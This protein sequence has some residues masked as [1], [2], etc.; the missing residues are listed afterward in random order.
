M[1]KTRVR[2]AAAAAAM[3]VLAAGLT[4][5][6]QGRRPLSLVELANIPRILD[7]QIAPDGRSVLYMLN[8]A[9]WKANR[10]VGHLWR[11]PI[12]GGAPTQLTFGDTGESFGRW[13][14]DGKTILFLRGGQV[15]LL[16]VDGGEPRA[17]TRHATAT[18]QPTWSPD[19]TA[20]YFVSRDA[21]TA[22]ERERTSTNDDLAPFEESLKQVHLWKAVVATG[23]EQRLTEGDWSVLGYK[24]S[25]DGKQIVLQ[26]APSTL[27]SDAFRGEVWIVDA[28]GQNARAV[29]RNGIDESE[30]QLSPDNSTILF[31][32]D[33][34][35]RL[36]PYYPRAIFTMPAN[37][38]SLP[39]LLL[40]EFPYEIYAAMWSADGRSIYAL[41]SMGVH[42]EVFRIDVS[43]RRAEKLTEGRHFIPP[44]WSVSPSAGLMLIQFDE[45]TRFGDAWTLPLAGGTPTRV[46]GIYDALERDGALPRQEKIEWKGADGTT[47]EGILFYPLDYQA[48]RRY[49]LVVQMHGGPADADHYGAGP[50]L[51]M[52]YVPVLTAKG[53]AVLRP[54]YRG[55][56]GYGAA[57]LRDPIGGYFRNM[58]LDVL[59]GVD[60]LVARGIAD[61]DKLALMG[62]SAGGHLTNKLIT[63]TDRFKAASS[64]AG[65]ANWTSMFSQTD[66][67]NDRTLIFGGTPWQKNAPTEMYWEQSPLKYVANVKTPTL[68]FVGDN[69]N[70]VPKEQSIEMHRALKANG[71]PTRL[72]VGQREGHQWGELR[73][74]IAK[75]NYELEWF[76]KHLMG[77]GYTPEKAPADNE[78]DRPRPSSQ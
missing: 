6:A 8:R 69:D 15:Q 11:Q 48:G 30:A 45:P 50:G 41:V 26:R 4:V 3:A 76:E 25:R 35:A 62:W 32:A 12:G 23:A 19:G 47:V 72:Y 31:L 75:A 54:N 17:L 70:R 52:S 73:H 29:T 40:P 63:F 21:A 42:S 38:S 34:N 61:P 5:R 10:Q 43:G 1:G 71:V 37:G 51:I 53:Y 58:H 20:V 44:S 13:S 7:T 36:E 24:V 77:R 56:S 28:S 39:Q 27:A 59:A 49:P 68:F 2:R 22:E 67:R 66:T 57:F 46:T 64:G 16:P 74:Q 18:L 78:K 14:P 60:A 33:A 9:D 65:A 55:S